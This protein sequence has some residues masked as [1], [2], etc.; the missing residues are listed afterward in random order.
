M[1]MGPRTEVVDD[2]LVALASGDAVV[3]FDVMA[4]C[5]PT[6][7]EIAAAEAL[8]H[9]DEWFDFACGPWVAAHDAS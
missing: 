1:K 2:L 7:A 6:H 8:L 3:V 5:D 4:R 9:L